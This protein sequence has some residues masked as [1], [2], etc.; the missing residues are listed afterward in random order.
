MRDLIYPLTRLSLSRSGRRDYLR[1][2]VNEIVWPDCAIDRGILFAPM[3]CW[4]PKANGEDGAWERFENTHGL[5]EAHRDLIFVKNN[6]WHY[7]GTF[8][9]MGSTAL[10]T[11]EVGEFGANVRF[12]QVVEAAIS[13]EITVSK[14]HLRANDNLA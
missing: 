2:G 7:Y 10:S 13:P 4:N 8:E 5:Q 3:Y 11:D 9:I 14:L 12:L 6:S 1:I